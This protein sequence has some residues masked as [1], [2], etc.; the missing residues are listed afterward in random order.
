MKVYILWRVIFGEEPPE[1]IK[2]YKYKKDA[3]IVCERSN[4]IESSKMYGDYFVV[5][6]H[7]VVE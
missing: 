7:E 2:V 1:L 3:E 6:E 4:D 5:E